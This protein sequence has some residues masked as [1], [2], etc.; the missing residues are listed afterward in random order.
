MDLKEYKTTKMKDPAFKKAYEEMQPELNVIRV[1]VG[2][3]V[4]HHLTQKRSPKNRHCAN[5]NQPF[6]KWDKKPQ[7]PPASKVG[8]RHGYGA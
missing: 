2:A 1:I 5:R 7:H 8:G 4:S 3:R 6:G